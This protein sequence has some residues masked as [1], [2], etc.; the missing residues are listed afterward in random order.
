MKTTIRCLPAMMI[1]WLFCLFLGFSPQLRAQSGP[2]TISVQINSDTD[3]AEEILS[4]G[5]VDTGSSD[6][7]M[8]LDDGEIQM[9]G[10]RFSGVNVP[11]G[12]TI[13]NA[14]LQFTTKN[15]PGNTTNLTIRGEAADDA[16]TFVDSPN[17]SGISS[18]TNT[19][20]AINWAPVE[21]TTSGE[22]GPDQQSPNLSA[23]IQEIV[24]RAGWA[25]G[26]AL[27]LTVEGSGKRV[28]HS[29]DGIAAE[30]AELFITY[31]DL[32]TVSPVDQ[33]LEVQIGQP[34]N[35]AEENLLTGVVDLHSG[36]LELVIDKDPQIV[37]MR[38]EGINIPQGAIVEHAYI[39][40]TVD[41][42]T[43]NSVSL[44]LS[45]EDVDNAGAFIDILPNNISVRPKTS[46]TVSWSPPAWLTMDDA[47][48]DQQTPDLSAII[49][50]IIDRPGWVS[51]NSLAILVEGGANK[52]KAMSYDGAAAKA[53]KLI[54]DY[55]VCDSELA[56][57]DLLNFPFVV[58]QELFCEQEDRKHMKYDIDPTTGNIVVAWNRLINSD[59]DNAHVYFAILDP[60]YQLI[61]PPSG[62]SWPIRV[63]TE[64]STDMPS[65]GV[66]VEIEPSTG[67]IAIGYTK[68][69]LGSPSQVHGQ[70]Y[71]RV[72]HAGGAP[73]PSYTSGG[74]IFNPQQT[75][76]S[77]NPN[78]CYEYADHFDITWGPSDKL[79]FAFHPWGGLD[80]WAKFPILVNAFNVTTGTVVYT[81][82]YSPYDNS[83]NLEWRNLHN[84]EYHPTFGILVTEYQEYNIHTGPAGDFVVQIWDEDLTSSSGHLSLTGGKEIGFD[85]SDG[86]LTV[87]NE[88]LLT[89]WIR[90]PMGGGTQTVQTQVSTIENIGVNIPGGNLSISPML[91]LDVASFSQSSQVYFTQN[92]LHFTDNRFSVGYSLYDNQIISRR[93]HSYELD[94]ST[95]IYTAT[96][97]F[98]QTLYQDELDQSTIGTGTTFYGTVADYHYPDWSIK[99]VPG[100]AKVT[101]GGHIGEF[102]RPRSSTAD[103]ASDWLISGA[104][105]NFAGIIQPCSQLPFVAATPSLDQNYILSTTYRK[106]MTDL[107]QATYAGDAWQSITY[108]DGLG[109]ASQSQEV[110]RLPDGSTMIQPIE[111]D[112]FGRQP[113][114]FMP[115]GSATATGAFQTNPL[116]DQQAFYASEFPDYGTNRLFAE[117]IFETS[118]LN[119]VVEAAMPGDAWKPVSAGG[120]GHT[121]KSRT[122][123]YG[124]VEI[125]SSLVVPYFAPDIVP[126]DPGIVADYTKYVEG[127]SR[128]QHPRRSDRAEVRG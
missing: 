111:Y 78:Y 18:R 25:S 96:P 105:L 16:G 27:V 115:Y 30:A 120:N 94:N 24:D 64:A 61:A 86:H 21:W 119:R 77:S 42:P 71:H 45:G 97:A 14:Y 117:S 102:L 122:F 107:T 83:M 108:F 91:Q 116:A 54:I 82:A 2:V 104:D 12:V 92:D 118:P 85:K 11:P 23:I 62:Q 53:P 73:L 66:N 109:R 69:L 8:V 50:E 90:E 49:Q 37:G 7:E 126:G 43:G 19:S 74:I 60:N 36:D 48:P 88:K 87:D 128:N 28:A 3:D 22:R 103:N 93:V 121:S 56:D 100:Q 127:N 99:L 5:E 26:N 35:D 110:G 57:D 89:S 70:F 79:Y 34:D 75:C 67:R 46:S 51:G 65:R 10:M 13:T 9:V 72:F 15:T 44:F 40:F 39:Q 4:T 84:I 31:D 33:H 68:M 55:K 6:L 58:G 59:N 95:G 125:P 81:N 47:G 114:A 123:I 38:F 124:S 20:A 29:H 98:P 76:S 52:R 41:D 106:E 101:A 63:D 32:E 17:S 1:A 80:W 113:K 112:A